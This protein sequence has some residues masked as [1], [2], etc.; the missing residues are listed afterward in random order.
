RLGVATA[1]LKRTR[2]TAAALASR[3][4]EAVS[5]AQM[6]EHAVALQR[7]MAHDDGPATAVRLIEEAGGHRN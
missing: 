1:P 5:S 2:L 6:K 3:I 4:R 7:R